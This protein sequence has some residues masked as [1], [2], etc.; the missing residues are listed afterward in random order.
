MALQLEACPPG[1]GHATFHYCGLGTHCARHCACPCHRCVDARLGVRPCRGRGYR[2][3]TNRGQWQAP[4]YRSARALA[5]RNVRAHGCNWAAVFRMDR[6]G[7]GG[8]PGGGD[9][10]SCTYYLHAGWA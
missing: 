5:E 4:T 1:C 8:G 7:L 6:V 2:I 9:L 10:A 3:I